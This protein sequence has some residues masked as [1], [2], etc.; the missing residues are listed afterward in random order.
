MSNHI[1][2]EDVIEASDL[3]KLSKEEVVNVAEQWGVSKSGSKR[4]I[5]ER[6]V[7]AQQAAPGP[8][9]ADPLPDESL[10]PINPLTGEKV[11]PRIETYELTDP[12]GNVVTVT[13]NLDTGEH[14]VKP[15]R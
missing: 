3:E 4:E 10:D 6:I 2:V 9:D 1:P 13:R 5:A 7:K 8:D 12:D 14:E 15:S 11:E